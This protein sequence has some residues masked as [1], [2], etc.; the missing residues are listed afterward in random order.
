MAIQ[1][2]QQSAI[3]AHCL[4]KLSAAH[5]EVIDLVYYHGRSID[6]VAAITGVPASTV[7]TRMFYARNRIAQ[8]LDG[9]EMRRASRPA[10]IS[11]CKRHASAARNR[12]MANFH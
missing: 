3:L 10:E 6:E 4:I 5:R 1:R 11:P 12:A 7:K 2:R 9:F 8:L